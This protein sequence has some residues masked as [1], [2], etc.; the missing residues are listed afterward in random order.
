MHEIK[1]RYGYTNGHNWIFKVFTIEEIETGKIPS[2][3]DGH[4]KLTT[5]DLFTGLTDKNGKEIFENDV[6]EEG[7]IEFH[8]EYLG[9]F[10]KGDFFEGENKPLYDI[11]FV[12]IIG[13][14]HQNPELIN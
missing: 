8:N 3:I 13:N 5:R 7:I 2:G 12:E 11:P 14:V 1:I 10:V 6:I 9:F 4:L